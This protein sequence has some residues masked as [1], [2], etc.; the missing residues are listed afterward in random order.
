MRFTGSRAAHLRVSGHVSNVAIDASIESAREDQRILGPIRSG[1]DRW[2]WQGGDAWEE[3][4]DRNM[5]IQSVSN[6]RKRKFVENLIFSTSGRKMK[7]FD[8]K[9]KFS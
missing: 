1:E 9:Q 5:E 7:I 6:F 2:M 3:G 8:W 4:C